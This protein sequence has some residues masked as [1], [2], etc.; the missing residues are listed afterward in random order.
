M[1]YLMKTSVLGFALDGVNIKNFNYFSRILHV[2]LYRNGPLN[3]K[4]FRKSF[5]SLLMV[6]GYKFVV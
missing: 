1:F 4:K 2:K 6:P 3:H 5:S